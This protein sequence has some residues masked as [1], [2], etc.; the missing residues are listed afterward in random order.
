MQ[1]FFKV[2]LNVWCE[3]CRHIELTQSTPRIT[4][5]LRSDLPLEQLVLKNVCFESGIIETVAR[6]I[7]QNDLVT[8]PRHTCSEKEIQKLKKWFKNPDIIHDKNP[9]KKCSFPFLYQN[10]R[11]TGSVMF[12]PLLRENVRGILVFIAPPNITFSDRNEMLMN[13]L[14]EPFAVAIENDERL[15]ELTRL[16]KAAEADKRS[17]LSRLGREKMVD[18][19]VGQKSGLKAVMERIGLV[20]DSD[21]PVLI[22]GETGTG[23][24]LIARMI[25]IRSDRAGGPF[26]RIN[27]GAIPPELIDSQLFGHVKGAFTGAVVDKTG[28]FERADGGT[29]FLDEIGELPLAAQVRF[30]RVLQDGWI[31]RVGGNKSIHVDVRIIA[32]TNQDLATMVSEG[33]FREDL[34]Y[35]IAVFPVILPPLQQR[36]EDIPE[37]ANHFI[38]RAALRFRLTPVLPD[39]ADIRL[40]QSYD[41]PGNIR[42]FGAVIDRAVILGNGKTLE[43]SKSLGWTGEYSQKIQKI[44]QTLPELKT[45]PP[46][47]IRKETLN[48][49]MRS[50]IENILSQTHGRIDGPN[51]AAVILGLNPHTLRGRMRKLGIDWKRYRSGNG[52]D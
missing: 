30:L 21:M 36:P 49:I 51:G 12:G 40:L 52:A 47:R 15:R 11:T 32:A 43:I 41:W 17:L 35:R 3:A 25:H 42:E 19:V 44:N 2:L 10:K 34:W 45:V 7:P 14:L 29:L 22:L 38:H 31:E 4:A 48:V 46:S 18:T 9:Q 27:C 1:K 37:L 23:K 33:R 6:G 39:E 20:S 28:W 16:R 8:T 26:L 24:E 13:T 5:M 50:H